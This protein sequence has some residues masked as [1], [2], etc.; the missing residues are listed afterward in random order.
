MKGLSL[1][2]LFILSNPLT[3]KTPE[4]TRD[5]TTVLLPFVTPSIVMIKDVSRTLLKQKEEIFHK[6]PK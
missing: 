6:V 5:G 4:T 3:P 1:F 2:H